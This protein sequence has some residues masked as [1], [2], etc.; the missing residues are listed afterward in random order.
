MTSASNPYL[1]LLRSNRDYRNL[2]SALVV[3]LL[4]DW[5]NLIAVFVLLGEIAG[6]S[7]EVYAWVIVLKMLPSAILGPLAGVVADTFDRRA[8]MLL[9]DFN[10]LTV[11]A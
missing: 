5:L 2:F 8:V 7:A 9:S 10:L 11:F 3:S 1:T 6:A 4:G